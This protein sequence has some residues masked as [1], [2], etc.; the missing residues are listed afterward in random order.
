[1]KREVIW[2]FCANAYNE[3]KTNS[4]NSFIRTHLFFHLSGEKV[5]TGKSPGLDGLPTSFINYK[6]MIILNVLYIHV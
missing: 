2:E 1:M 4:V 3:M 5:N 6:M